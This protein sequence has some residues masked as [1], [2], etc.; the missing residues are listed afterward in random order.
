[1]QTGTKKCYFHRYSTKI[2]LLKGVPAF[3]RKKF[4]GDRI[5][6]KT[7]SLLNKKGKAKRLPFFLNQFVESYCTEM[8]FVKTPTVAAPSGAQYAAAVR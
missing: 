6:V 5:P 7:P 4:P 2:C 8:Y 3:E 1:M